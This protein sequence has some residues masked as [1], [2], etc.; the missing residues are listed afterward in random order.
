MSVNRIQGGY[1]PI[2][3]AREQ[4][5][6]QN[7]QQNKNEKLNDPNLQNPDM[8]QLVHQQGEAVPVQQSQESQ[9]ARYTD[10]ESEGG[11]SDQEDPESVEE[12][13]EKTQKSVQD[14]QDGLQQVSEGIEQLKEL[15]QTNTG[16]P[17][18]L[19][20]RLQKIS[21][22]GQKLVVD[23]EETVE[24]AV[25]EMLNIGNMLF[26][27]TVTELV[28]IRGVIDEFMLDMNKRQS[29]IPTPDVRDNSVRALALRKSKQN[30]SQNL[31][32][33]SNVTNLM[34]ETAEGSIHLLL[35][36]LDDI[37]AGF[38]QVNSG[39]A[40]GFKTV[41][42]GFRALFT[43]LMNIMDTTSLFRNDLEVALQQLAFVPEQLEKDL[44][45]RQTLG[46]PEKMSAILWQT[47]EKVDQCWRSIQG[48]LG[49]LGA[50]LINCG[51]LIE[52]NFEEASR[53]VIDE[54][55]LAVNSVNADLGDI[56]DEVK[57]TFSPSAAQ[58]VE[59]IL[60]GADQV[61]EALE[62]LVTVSERKHK[63]IKRGSVNKKLP[64]HFNVRL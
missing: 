25:T 18:G 8:A 44:G 15:S 29:R 61:E 45:N 48:N 1:S 31:A 9:E 3:I 49:L 7:V 40:D 2:E 10:R 21:H 43:S 37:R 39:E 5:Q 26:N 11:K 19:D 50:T 59:Q 28:A 24:R 17:K 57:D 22:M 12:M 46:I 62:D 64:A 58:A 36:S 52:A 42:R 47:P 27:S 32:N 33:I 55:Q 51:K 20:E 53:E 38:D 30:F 16:I 4:Q 6:Q 23:I 56:K 41:E 54:G 60:E 13:E 34:L 63:N 35:G 14:L